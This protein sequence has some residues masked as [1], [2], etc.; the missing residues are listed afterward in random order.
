MSVTKDGYRDY[1]KSRDMSANTIDAYC[2]GL[3]HLAQHS[4]RDLWALT[5]P[6]QLD[7]LRVDYGQQGQH[8]EA[9]D[10]SN[11]SARNALR[12]WRDY[13]ASATSAG[14]TTPATFLLTW[15]PEHY[16]DGGNAGVRAGQIERW[17][18]NSTKPV[19]GDRCLSDPSWC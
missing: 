2:S 11:G 7:A 19:A 12:Y 1:L 9:G 3:N 5:D 4:K 16:Q 17:S 18:C 8:A 15:N 14:E 6:E 13:V 10:Y